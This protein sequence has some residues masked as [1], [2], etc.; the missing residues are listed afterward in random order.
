LAVGNRHHY[1]GKV[2]LTMPIKRNWKA[3]FGMVQS[4]E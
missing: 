4:F 2:R 3:W 1:R